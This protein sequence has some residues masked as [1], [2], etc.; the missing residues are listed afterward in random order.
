M[1]GVLLRM[2]SRPKSD[3]APVTTE[4]VPRSSVL[5]AEI[6]AAIECVTV[7]FRQSRADD[8]DA[9]P[10]IWGTFGRWAWNGT[11]DAAN[12]ILKVWPDLSEKQ[13]MR[14]AKLLAGQIARQNRKQFASYRP[15]GMTSLEMFDDAERKFLGDWG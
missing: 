8:D 12:R 1:I 5:P 6:V 2:F 3:P 15:R 14:A 10:I 4:A 13:A 11:S 9:A 7:I